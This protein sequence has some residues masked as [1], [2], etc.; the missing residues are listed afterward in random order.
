MTTLLDRRQQKTRKA[1]FDAFCNLIKQHS[2]N[3]ITVQQ[4]IDEANVGRSTFYAHFPTK[5][6]LLRAVCE[7]LF[8]HIIEG[9]KDCTLQRRMA[10]AEGHETESVFCHLLQHLKANDRN[11]LGLLSSDNSQFFLQYFKDE[12][13]ILILG[14]MEKD[15]QKLTSVPADLQINFVASAFI[16]LVL[17][18]NKHHKQESP[19][20][21]DRY[22]RTLISPV[23][24]IN[25]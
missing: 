14:I 11:I 4:I 22:F 9:A 18:W 15:R 7:D 2:Y 17:W 1:I 13:K 5:D 10:I 21:L 3:N 25:F 23:L 6:D 20:Q 8:Y 19:E 16:E 12:L 24:D